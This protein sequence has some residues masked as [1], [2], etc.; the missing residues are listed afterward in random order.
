[1]YKSTRVGISTGRPGGRE[2]SMVF[3]KRDVKG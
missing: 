2:L 1:M 3:V